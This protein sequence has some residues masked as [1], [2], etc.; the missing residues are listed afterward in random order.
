[1]IGEFEGGG[2]R[3]APSR[4]GACFPHFICQL[5]WLCTLQDHGCLY[6]HVGKDTTGSHPFARSLH[7]R[8]RYITASADHL[9][10]RSDICSCRTCVSISDHPSPQI[11]RAC[12]LTRSSSPLGAVRFALLRRFRSGI[13]SRVRSWVQRRGWW[14]RG[15]G[16]GETF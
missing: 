11:I 16:G 2:V 5:T 15:C 8:T 10:V 6:P 4:P 12:K 3:R 1:M 7:D 13:R 14:I 9:P